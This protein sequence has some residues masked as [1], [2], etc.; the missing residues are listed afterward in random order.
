MMKKKEKRPV[1][2]FLNAILKINLTL[3]LYTQH[4]A[5]K[6]TIVDCFLLKFCL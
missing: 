3:E 2:V 6:S 1:V 4:A 5:R